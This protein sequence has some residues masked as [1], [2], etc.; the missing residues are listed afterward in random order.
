MKFNTFSPTYLLSITLY[1]L[2]IKTDSIQLPFLFGAAQSD[3]ESAVKIHYSI[4][5]A[6]KIY[7]QLKKIN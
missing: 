6:S 1:F 3:S 5:R 7:E 4:K 2:Y